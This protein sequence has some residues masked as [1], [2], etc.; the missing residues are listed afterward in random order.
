M[1]EKKKSAKPASRAKETKKARP[2]KSQKVTFEEYLKLA[3]K[4]GWEIP[5][6]KK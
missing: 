2:V 4:N 5:R 6:D 3:K 1:T